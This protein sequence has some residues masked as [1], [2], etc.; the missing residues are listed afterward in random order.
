MEGAEP[1][2]FAKLLRGLANTKLTRTGTFRTADEEGTALRCSYKVPVTS[3]LVLGRLTRFPICSWVLP[4]IAKYPCCPTTYISS[5]LQADDGYLYPLERAFFYVHKPPLLLIYDDIESIE[6][7]RQGGGV[8]AASAKTF[9]LNIRVSSQVH[10]IQNSMA[11]SRDPPSASVLRSRCVIYWL[12]EYLF[13]GLDKNE[14]SNL[15]AF[16][17]AKRLRIE[18]LQEAQAGPGGPSKPLDLGEDIDTGAPTL[19]SPMQGSFTSEGRLICIS[20]AP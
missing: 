1:E 16:I 5:I 8:L 3:L 9:D 7:L 4:Y 13:R 15:F 11:I 12:Q 14:W 6:F 18:N 10:A 20:M 19:L 2:V 17:Q